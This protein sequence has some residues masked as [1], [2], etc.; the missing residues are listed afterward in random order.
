MIRMDI[1][2]EDYLSHEEIKQICRDIVKTKA[3]EALST[4]SEI[5][6]ILNNTSYDIV[7]TAVNEIIPEDLD[8]L[9]RDK[10]IEITQSLSSYSVFKPKDAWERE[11]TKGWDI[12]QKVISD[13]EPLIRERVCQ[14][15]REI[16]LHHIRELINQH[17][18]TIIHS[19]V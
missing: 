19:L 17:I 8:V 11:N 13:E 15:I 7:R 1:K 9:L 5:E 12:L 18:D 10:V 16:D 2:I 4:T 6:R 14:I 3:R